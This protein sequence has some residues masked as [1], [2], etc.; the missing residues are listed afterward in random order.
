MVLLRRKQMSVVLRV[1]SKAKALGPLTHFSKCHLFML[2]N[3]CVTEHMETAT[4]MLMSPVE[5]SFDLREEC[6]DPSSSKR[7]YVVSCVH[8]VSLIK[9]AFLCT[10]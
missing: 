9:V 1:S 10:K 6:P 2:E 7:I 3:T 5:H 4:K 8:W